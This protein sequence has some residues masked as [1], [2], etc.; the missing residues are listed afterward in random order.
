MRS[1]PFGLAGSIPE[2][3]PDEHAQGGILLGFAICAVGTTRPKRRLKS[4]E[5]IVDARVGV[6]LGVECAGKL[7]TMAYGG[8]R[9]V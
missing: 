6:K 7:V 4:E 1:E 9:V 2:H 5:Q 3:V 8:N